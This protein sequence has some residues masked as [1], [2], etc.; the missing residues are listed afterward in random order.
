MA[1][2][3]FGTAWNKSEEKALSLNS[4]EN[5]YFLIFFEFL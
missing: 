3:V 4:A 5:M 2:L 1:A